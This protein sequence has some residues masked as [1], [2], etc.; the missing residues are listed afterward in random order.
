MASSDDLFLAIDAGDAARIRTVLDEEASLATSRD[1]QGVSALMRALYRFDPSLTEAIRCCVPTLD[2]FEAAALDD[3]DRLIDLLD[4]DPSL[5]TA[6]S[7]DGFNALHLSAFFGRAEAA[8][9]LLAYGARVDPRGTGWMTGTPLHSA[10]SAGHA[11]LAGILLD[12]GADPNARQSC[13]WTP[14]HSA[15]HNG[16]LELVD[17]LLRRGADAGAVNDAGQTVMALAESAGDAATTRV[18]RAL[19][20]G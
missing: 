5:A 10:A 20:G 2:V 15:A 1:A 14:L 19:D 18:R 13:G 11:D 9:T 7:G 12:A 17:L 16:D 4:A 8:R 3:V 6:A